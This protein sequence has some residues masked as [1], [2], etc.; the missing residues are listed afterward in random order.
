MLV[1]K[2]ATV[3]SPVQSHRAVYNYTATTNLNKR[4]ITYYEIPCHNDFYNVTIAHR[5]K[6]LFFVIY[7]IITHCMEC[8]TNVEWL[9]LPSNRKRL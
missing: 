9:L 5:T 3:S 6:G 4:R 7:A 8:S 1:S 2:T